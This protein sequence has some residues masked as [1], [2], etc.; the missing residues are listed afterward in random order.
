MSVN[1]ARMGNR[2]VASSP[3]ACCLCPRSGFLRWAAGSWPSLGKYSTKRAVALSS[4]AFLLLVGLG[5]CTGNQDNGINSSL[6]DAASNLD[7]L[8]QP[9][10]STDDL[11][12]DVTAVDAADD[13]TADMADSGT[14]TAVDEICNGLDDNCNGQT[15]EGLCDDSNVCTADQC[16]VQVIGIAGTC[17]HT[18]VEGACDDGSACTLADACLAGLC[19]GGK[20]ADCNDENPC[21]SDTCDAATGSCSHLN[22]EGPCDD[23][24]ACTTGEVCTAGV[25]T[26]GSTVDCADTDVCTD[27]TCDAAKGCVHTLNTAPCSDGNGCTNGDACSEGTC[28]PGIATPCDDSNICTSDACNKLDGTCSH[29]PQEGPCDD[30]DGCTN[31]DSCQGGLCTGLAKDCSDTNDCT[32][33]SCAEGLCLHKIVQVGLACNDGNPCTLSDACDLAGQCT[34]TGL[35]CDDG[36]PCTLDICTVADGLCHAQASSGASCDDGT[37]CTLGDACVDGLCVGGLI[38][39]C[40]DGNPCTDDA[41]D[42]ASGN[43]LFTSSSV[44]CDDGNP[45]TVGDICAASLCQSGTP[46]TC[47]DGNGC[48][49]D[50]CDPSSGKCASKASVDGLGCE[51]GILCTQGDV[52]KGGQCNPGKPPQCDDGNPCTVDACSESTGKC[53][54]VNTDGG[55]CD[56]GNGCT[57]GDVC[58]SGSCQSGVITCQCQSTADCASSEDGDLCNGTLFCDLKSHTCQIDLKTVVVCDLSQNTDCVSWGCNKLLGKCEPKNQADSKAC[59]ADKSVCTPGDHCVAGICTPGDAVT[60]DDANPCTD[61]SCD[62][63]KGCAAKANTAP[64]TDGNACTFND[65]C[66]NSTCVPG[67]KKTCDDGDS[68]TSDGCDPGTGVCFTQPLSGTPCSDANPCT[69]GDI[70][71]IGLC[72]PT[73]AKVCDDGNP[74]TTDQCD[75]GTG[76]CVT[77]NVA[78]GASCE[79]GSLC[80]Q[81]D[82]CKSGSCASGSLKVCDDGNICTKDACDLKTGGCAVVAV[83]DGAPCSDG[84]A[85]TLSD[86][87][88]TGACAPGANKVCSGSDPCT[89]AS[90]D[91]N[92]GK[93]V[94][95]PDGLLC[96]DGNAC[97]L[98]DGCQN[99]ACVPAS[100]TTCDDGNPCTTDSCDATSGKCLYINNTNACS[101]NNACTANDA[102]SG[103]ICAGGLKNCNDYNTCT[104][105]SCDPTKGCLHVAT[106]AQPCD[107][108][109]VCTTG[110]TCTAGN[111]V[112]VGLQCVDGN[113]CTAD[114]CDPIK[115]CV[116]IASSNGACSDGNACTLG[117]VC[118]AG[119]CTPGKQA[120]CSDGKSCTDDICDPANGNCTYVNNNANLCSDNNAC[121]ADDH[122]IAGLCIGGAVQVN[123][124]DKNGCTADFCDPAKGCQH[125]N[126]SAAPCSDGNA[127]TAPDV[128]LGG[129][130]TSGSV[131]NCDD[132]N[133]CT[134]DS[135]DTAKGCL[136]VNNTAV[137]DDGNACLAPDACSGGVCTGSIPVVCDDLNACTID[138]CDKTKGCQHLAAPSAN[139][140]SIT[141]TS[142]VGDLVSTDAKD[143][144][145]GTQTYYNFKPSVEV[146]PLPPTFATVTDASW[147]WADIAEPLP[148]AYT[149]AEFTKTFN[150]PSS[151]QI[152]GTLTVAANDNVNCWLNNKVVV[153]GFLF[154]SWQYPKTFSIKAALLVGNNSLRCDVTHSGNSS[155]DKPLQH[156]GFA[157]RIDATAYSPGAACD[158]GNA[159]TSGDTCFGGNC[160][161]ASGPTCDDG[162]PCTKDTCSIGGGCA[163]TNADGAACDDNNPCTLK[164]A[165]AVGVCKG[166]TNPN[167]DDGSPCSKDAC[168]PNLG[169][170]H[171]P[172]TTGAFTVAS[173]GSDTSVTFTAAD[174]S[175]KP[176]VLAWDLL[177]GW[178]HAINGAKWV[179]QE[180][181]VSAPDVDTTVVFSKTFNIAAGAIANSG[182]LVIATDGA[183]VCL[184][185]GI[186]E[187]VEVQENNY[188]TPLT[189]NITGALQVGTNTLT[190]TVVNPGKVGA[191]GYTNPAGLLFRV[192]IDTFGA[193][194]TAAC[195][196]GNACTSNDFCVSLMCVGGSITSCDDKNACTSDY[197]D[198]VKGCGH[199]ANSATVCDDN[200]PCTVGDVCSNGACVGGGAT[201]CD[202]N[203]PCTSDPCNAN[204]GCSHSNADGLACNDNNACTSQDTCTGGVCKPLN[205][206][207]CDDGNPCTLDG[208]QPVTGCYH[209]VDNTASCNDGNTCTTG[210]LCSGGLCVGGKVNACDDGNACTTDSCDPVKGCAHTPASGNKCEDGDACTT[211]EQCQNGTCT[212]GLLKACSDGNPCTTD[213][214]DPSNGNCAFTVV[215]S[216]PCE[217]GNL[218]TVNDA[219][220]SGVCKAG[221]PRDCGDGNVCTA[222]G[223]DPTSGLCTH[224][225]SPGGQACDDSDACTT[226]D[227]CTN[228]KCLGQGKNCD[229]GNT[230]T[231]DSCDHV[232]G[233]CSSKVLSD[234]TACGNGGTC[235]QGVCK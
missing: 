141:V 92:S 46:T 109:S 169:C 137:C 176:A 155:P 83:A 8:I 51:D 140:Q 228:G 62:P 132:S 215:L 20:V 232:T 168:D 12:F 36:N 234:G 182:T 87:C 81:N 39:V 95:K 2:D 125:V 71:N 179:W 199:T 180:Q 148:G 192:D 13:V 42:G 230:C 223:C 143:N 202:D 10:D 17:T 153:G 11:P 9:N 163:H 138:S 22:V 38:K 162:N 225:A 86:T 85:C 211:G 65:L 181:V 64:C 55:T 185:N 191:T 130:C 4:L 94:A 47:D 104:T 37:G 134:D 120:Q 41:C 231:G 45:C 97:S 103:G 123:C 170:T 30:G 19:V 145:N 6:A 216:G 187:G 151:S 126:N 135:C 18:A 217:D 158:D 226:S 159:C 15:D 190:C 220:N 14:C 54:F 108:G 172:A 197:C 44:V 88:K 24:S 150:M 139:N 49:I 171:K 74:C 40:N 59:D 1:A 33:D 66:A 23:G 196:D 200:N 57:T 16:A 3:D 106:V 25:C 178:N 166:G 152:D 144:G 161:G 133:A 213:G 76:N 122:C 102:C 208:C 72:K 147:V 7:G 229:D 233:K 193:G 96:D 198:P 31:N 34:G 101:D 119:K 61:D 177:P 98:G 184:V 121:S 214:C 205:G 154:S 26:G 204:S 79:D 27:D 212:G 201:S 48:T 207:P 50:A 235:F 21:T 52:C 63:L 127:C 218:C 142:A 146:I 100:F 56:D 68:C 195:S 124:D 175:Q 82:T 221:A 69:F 189:L 115:G 118:V 107:D 90:C 224:V 186:L 183:F 222:D 77:K 78:D 136:H 111:C 84:N 149:A 80:T 157:W 194:S 174:G 67:T 32:S 219:C 210:D 60:C 93:C 5:A 173:T 209:S 188:V 53:A 89:T 91:I 116:F 113:P 73:S 35:V 206:A 131:L 114:T 129:K 58:K 203:N 110:D 160:I 29:L 167:C 70:C 117:D 165:C 128:C 227:Q 112:G 156:G 28:L 164:D 99:G 43:C 105:D 75:G